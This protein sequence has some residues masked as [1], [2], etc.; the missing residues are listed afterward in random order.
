MPNGQ[1]VRP[2]G[3]LCRRVMVICSSASNL[4][5]GAV[6]PAR[7]VA[8]Y[9]LTC[10]YDLCTTIFGGRVVSSTYGLTLPKEHPIVIGDELFWEG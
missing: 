8:V 10:G 3:Q 1:E 6:A 5:L 7:N 2:R 4:A 9:R